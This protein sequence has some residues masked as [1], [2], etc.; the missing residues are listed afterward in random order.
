MS[1]D[2]YLH[3]RRIK[4]RALAEEMG[5]THQTIYNR[6]KAG[7]EVLQLADGSW[8]MMSTKGADEVKKP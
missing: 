6:Q 8:H 5:T 4:V 1:I 2:D 3:A 7:W